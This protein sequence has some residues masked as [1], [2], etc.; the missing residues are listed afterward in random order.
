MPIKSDAPRTSSPA[1]PP[2]LALHQAQASFA[3]RQNMKK[4]DEEE[5]EEETKN[6]RERRKKEK[7]RLR[8]SEA[9]APTKDPEAHPPP[10]SAVDAPTKTGPNGREPAN[11]AAFK[12]ASA[13]AYVVFVAAA[14]A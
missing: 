10:F 6:G 7:R 5:E 2:L 9:C 11:A 4:G 3:G 12:H 14:A 13:P 8:A 1:M